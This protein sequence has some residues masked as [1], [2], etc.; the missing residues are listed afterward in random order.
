VVAVDLAF[1]GVHG[2]TLAFGATL[3]GEAVDYPSFL[4]TQA[5]R[6]EPLSA[7]RRR[8]GLWLRLAVLTTACGSVALLLSGFRGLVQLGMLTA[9]GIVAAGLVTWYGLPRWIP[10]QWTGRLPAPVPAVHLRW[11]VRRS[12]GLAIAAI[13]PVL[14]LALAWGKP[15]WNDDPARLNPLPMN[16]VAR[17]R[18]L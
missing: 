10:P 4:L 11:R 3:L 2:I 12:V 15:V 13:A 1:G 7:T 14:V 6:G 9:V 17:D 18:E 16:L 8:I 5:A